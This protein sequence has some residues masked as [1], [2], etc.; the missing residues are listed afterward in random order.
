MWLFENKIFKPVDLDPKSTYGFIYEITNL[1]N[2]KKYIGKKYPLMSNQKISKIIEEIVNGNKLKTNNKCKC[3]ILYVYMLLVIM[4]YYS[5]F[6]I[7]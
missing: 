5:I 6:F 7:Q 2:Q 1:V 3:V 4:L